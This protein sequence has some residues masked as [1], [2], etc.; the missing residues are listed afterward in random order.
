MFED[1][2]PDM[3]VGGL[4]TDFIFLSYIRKVLDIE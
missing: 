3:D 1:E 4:Q 2:D